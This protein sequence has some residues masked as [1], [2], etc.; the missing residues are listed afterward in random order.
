MG[1]EMHQRDGAAQA[2]RQRAQQRQGDAVFAAQ[3]DQVGDRCGLRLDRR[4][5]S[6][7]VAQGDPKSPMSETGMLAGSTQCSGWSPSVSIRLARRIAAGPSRVPE[8]LVVPMSIG[9]PAIT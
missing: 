5:A 7:D 1:V 9:M 4:Q 2:L 6:L 3:G 8:R